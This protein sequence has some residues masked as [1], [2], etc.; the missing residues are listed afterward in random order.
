MLLSDD[1]KALIYVAVDAMYD[2]HPQEFA[3]IR[4]R[5]RDEWYDIVEMDWFS[6]A[7]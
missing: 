2:I 1:E 5:I 7:E 6:E 3:G 4:R